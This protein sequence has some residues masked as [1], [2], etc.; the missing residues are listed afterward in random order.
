MQTTPKR[1]AIGAGGGCVIGGIIGNNV[2][3]ET[4]Q[5]WAL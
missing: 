4:I 3:S 5:L 2:E 1:G